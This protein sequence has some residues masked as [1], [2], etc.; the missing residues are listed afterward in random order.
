MV[1]LTEWFQKQKN[2]QFLVILL[3]EISPQKLNKWLQKFYLSAR[4]R[5]GRLIISRQN[6]NHWQQ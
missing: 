4:K 5:E 6:C 2:Q 1:V 3:E